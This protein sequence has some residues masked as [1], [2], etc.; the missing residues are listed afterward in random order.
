M[1]RPA[2]HWVPRL[3]FLVRPV[4]PPNVPRELLV[5]LIASG[6]LFSAN[7][8]RLSLLSMDD[9]FYARIALEAERSGRFFTM[10]WADRPNFQKP[11]LQ[12]WL[13][14]RFFAVFGEHDWSARLPSI[15]M[16]L[17]ILV[18]T[19][20]IGVLTVGP[21]AA[22][23]GV[24]GL[25]LS[26]YFSDHAR[27]VMQEVPLAFWTAL[28]MLTF[29]ESRRRPRLMVLFALP[30]GAAILTKSVLGLLPLLVLLATAIAVPGLRGTLKNPWTWTG[31]VGGLALAASWTIEQ[32]WT[33]GAAALKEHYLGEVGPRAL[34]SADPLRFLLGY[35]WQLMDSYQPVIL[36]AV[37]GAFVLWRNRAARGE[38]GLVPVVW[39][40]V[41]ILALNFLSGRAPRYIFPV[42]PALALCGGFWLAHVAPP[43]ARALRRSIAPALLLAAAV[44]L[45]TVPDLLQPLL[46][47]AWD[48]NHDIKHSRTLLQ[49]LIPRNEP[50]AFLGGQYWAKASPLL[51][52]TDRRLEVPDPTAAAALERAASRP[53][54]LLVCDRDRLYEIDSAV[55]PYRIVFETRNW[56]LLKLL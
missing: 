17:G 27:R 42:F 55:T 13:V 36:P 22:L 38:T 31:I 8:P 39:A 34:T 52:Y 2:Y 14:G 54:R 41:P 10:T 25:A 35:P 9:A 50:V 26:P 51:Y 37:L 48:Q 12:S 30:L 6:L 32:G 4:A 40:F 18:M 21:A 7:A 46:Q 43:V 11:P 29:L 3:S 33:F 20:R 47:S 16:A 56:A 28:A 5:L 19:H 24:A 45:W 53:S 15:L 44:I 49:A 1:S 23:T